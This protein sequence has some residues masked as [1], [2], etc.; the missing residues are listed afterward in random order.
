MDSELREVAKRHS[1]ES[2]SDIHEDQYV[3]EKDIQMLEDSEVIDLVKG[4]IRESDVADWGY[5]QSYKMTPCLGND[6]QDLDIPNYSTT[7]EFGNDEFRVEFEAFYPMSGM[8]HND[9]LFS[10]VVYNDENEKV[11]SIYDDFGKERKAEQL[12][13][14]IYEKINGITVFEA[15][16]NM[17]RKIEANRKKR[18]NGMFSLFER[19]IR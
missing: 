4:V 9:D 8:Y 16:C 15:K 12:Y 17:E 13:D 3:I 10:M 18:K 5:T 1:D 19:L 7:F 6:G 2:V 14:S 11:L